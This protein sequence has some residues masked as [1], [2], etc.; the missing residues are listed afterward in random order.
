MVKWLSGLVWIMD[1]YSVHSHTYFLLEHMGE[2]MRVGAERVGIDLEGGPNLSVPERASPKALLWDK[3]LFQGRCRPDS[4][5]F[6]AVPLPVAV[7]LHCPAIRAGR[8]RER[9][10]EHHH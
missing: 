2:P 4:S 1:E 5:G 3:F 9:E 6:S 8:E 10:R 7:P